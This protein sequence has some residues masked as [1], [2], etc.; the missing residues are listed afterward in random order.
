MITLS[1]EQKMSHKRRRV[2]DD[3]KEDKEKERLNSK[4]SSTIR[5]NLALALKRNRYLFHENMKFSFKEI[6][7]FVF[8]IRTCTIA[9]CLEDCQPRA[10]GF[11]RSYP[12]I[13]SDCYQ[14]LPNSSLVG[15]LI[16]WSYNSDGNFDELDSDLD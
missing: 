1:S 14:L 3:I 12:H 5:I 6:P 15:R 16:S 11:Y 2:D 13:Q 8:P 9:G 7:N 4:L 10:W